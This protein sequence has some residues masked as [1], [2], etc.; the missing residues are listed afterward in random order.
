MLDE[1]AEIGLAE[2]EVAAIA[3]AELDALMRPALS[4]GVAQGERALDARAADL[5]REIVAGMPEP[6]PRH[7]LSAAVKRALDSVVGS[8]LLLVAAPD[9][10]VLGVLV[11]REDGGPMFFGHERLMRNGRIRRC[12][13]LRTMRDLEPADLARNG[14]HAAYAANDFK[15]ASSDP[16]ITK[17]GRFMRGRY[18]DELPQLWN[19]VRGD[20]SLVGPRPVIAEEVRWWGPH[21][22]EFLSV[23]PGLFGAWQLT[24]HMAY[25]DRAYLEL[26]YV[27]SATLR[28]DVEIFGKTCGKLLLRKSHVM[29]DLM[30]PR[31][32]VQDHNG[33]PFAA[34]SE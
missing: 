10:A 19:V 18:L 5:W 28:I 11:K 3:L 32:S 23:R 17:I 9:I 30:P 33:T 12:W 34:E 8:A 24:D 16:R 26:A 13:K 25:P 31:P 14:A 27:R 22:R 2:P 6:R 1:R 15:L 29:E 21:Q 20:M 4:N 7:R